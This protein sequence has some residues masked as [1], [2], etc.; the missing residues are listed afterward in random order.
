M[1]VIAAIGRAGARGG[2]RQRPETKKRCV[3]KH[4]SFGT[5]ERT[6]KRRRRPSRHA[7]KIPRRVARMGNWVWLVG[8]MTELQ[9]QSST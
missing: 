9:A 7:E 5:T 2:N 4:Q 1:A 6:L 8:D 3:L